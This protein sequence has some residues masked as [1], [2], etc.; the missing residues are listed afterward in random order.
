MGRKLVETWSWIVSCV[1]LGKGSEVKG[2]AP[3]ACE[4]RCEGYGSVFSSFGNLGA[5]ERICLEG[6]VGG[7]RRVA[8]K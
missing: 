4:H 2:G 5:V 7:V 8:F 6:K 3:L 1:V